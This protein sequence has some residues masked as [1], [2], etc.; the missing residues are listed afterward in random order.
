MKLRKWDGIPIRPLSAIE[1][2]NLE[3]S[4][5]HSGQYEKIKVMPDG[6]IIDGHHRFEILGDA[7]QYEIVDVDYDAAFGMA[8]AIN[9]ARRQLTPDQVVEVQKALKANKE[10]QKATAE[11]LRKAGKTQEE[12]AAVLGVARQTVDK[13]EDTTNAK[14]GN[15]CTKEPAADL[16]DTP[17]YRTKV[18]KKQKEQ[19]AQR[20]EEG[21]TQAEIAADFGITQQAVGKIISKHAEKKAKEYAELEQKEMLEVTL[22]EDVTGWHKVGNQFLYCGSNTDSAF[23]GNVP[24]CALAF[25]DPPYNADVAEWDN[26]FVWQQDYLQ[27]IAKVVCVTPGGWNAVG[28]YRQTKMRYVWEIACWIKNGMTH[29]RCG[30]ANWIKTSVF[31]LENPRISQDHF[32]VTINTGQTEETSHKGRK[33][34]QYLEQIILMFT[35]ESDCIIDPFAG[36]GQ[37]LL[38]S[39]KMKRISY[40]AEIEP[41]FVKSI[42]MRGMERGLAYERL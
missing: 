25:A 20:A 39:E 42:I 26:N 24:E 6:L 37:T 36:S 8:I 32:S 16:F 31:G 41:E 40:N 19:I 2:K 30:Y 10:A 5:R 14:N 22:G 17:D 23:T 33:P 11:A 9:L 27:D 38:V 18:T 12:T 28:F 15:S 3:N 13:W 7:V 4:I 21:E 29:G 1:K 34:E 35:A